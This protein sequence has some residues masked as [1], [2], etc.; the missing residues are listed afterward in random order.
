MQANYEAEVE[1]R[2]AAEKELADTVAD[3]QA[4]KDAAAAAAAAAAERMQELGEELAAATEVLNR[5]EGENAELK[6]AAEAIKGQYL[7][8]QDSVEAEQ[9]V[10]MRMQAEI[11]R[12]KRYEIDNE[13]LASENKKMKGEVKGLGASLTSTRAALEAAK[14][15]AVT[16]RQKSEATLNELQS[17][18]DNIQSQVLQVRPP[19]ALSSISFLFSWQSRARCCKW[20]RRTVACL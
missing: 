16:Q 12:L 18:L 8:A 6:A 10:V 11:A 15:E 5:Q 7:V 2:A 20:Q 14:A 17:A 13:Y 1:K 9:G 4:T 3:L 19:P